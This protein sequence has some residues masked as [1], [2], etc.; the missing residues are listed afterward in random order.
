M[1]I[2]FKKISLASMAFSALMVNFQEAKAN[3]LNYIFTETINSMFEYNGNTKAI[4][5][6]NSS[7]MPGFLVS[8]GDTVHGTFSYVSAA[9]LTQYQPSAQTK[10]SYVMYQG[11][12]TINLTFDK[13]NTTVKTSSDSFQVANDAS[14]FSGS[15]IFFIGANAT[16]SPI[17]SQEV[18]VSLDDSKGTVFTSSSVPQ[19]LPLSGFTSNLVEYTF[20]RQS[21]GSQLHANGQIT[22]LSQEAT[23][24]TT[25]PEPESY[26]MLLTG[27]GLMGFTLRRR[28]TS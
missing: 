12:A 13:S 28:K 15:D 2:T 6:V 24:I 11:A 19:K 20:L 25:V 26:A 22:S 27:L 16:Y 1:K 5:Y 14:T 9:P 18:S 3:I 21:D 7:S 10:G 17:K 8:N 23:T 4:S